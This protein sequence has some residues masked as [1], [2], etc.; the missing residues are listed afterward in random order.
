M[1]GD[2]RLMEI[3][4]T[5]QDAIGMCLLMKHTSTSSAASQAFFFRLSLIL[6]L[7]EGGI[8][9]PRIAKQG[10]ITSNRSL[11]FDVDVLFAATTS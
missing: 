9:H 5:S 8:P 4:G 7:K 11:V 1:G 10:R 3:P 2:L 6:K